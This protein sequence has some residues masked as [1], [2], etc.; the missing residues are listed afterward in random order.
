MPEIKNVDRTPHAFVGALIAQQLY[1]QFYPLLSMLIMAIE[2]MAVFIRSVLHMPAATSL[3][4][5]CQ[6]HWERV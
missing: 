5:M 2:N 6:L 4:I 3:I 1:P